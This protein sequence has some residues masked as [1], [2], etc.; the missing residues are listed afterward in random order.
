MTAAGKTT[1]A[2][3]LAE[4]LGFSY[5]GMSAILRD[6]AG[7]TLTG[8]REWTPALDAFRSGNDDF[9]RRCD[10]DMSRWLASLRGPVVVDAWLQAWLCDS[11]EALRIWL[12]SDRDSRL[13]KCAVSYRRSGDAPPCELAPMLDAKDGFSVERFRRL[14]GISFG[15]DDDLFDLYLDNSEYITAPTVRASDEGIAA[16]HPIFVN[17]VVDALRRQ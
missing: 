13:A 15:Y 12:E 8:T 1:H 3:L 10:E 5:A 7:A 14:Y 17:A 11:N 4:S 16:F 2:R 9:D 6:R